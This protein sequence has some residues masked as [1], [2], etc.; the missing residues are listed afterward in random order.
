MFVGFFAWLFVLW[1][2]WIDKH[3][4]TRV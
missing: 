4:T 3:R 2:W 1:A